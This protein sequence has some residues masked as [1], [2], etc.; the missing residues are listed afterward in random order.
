MSGMERA[1]GERKHLERWE[2]PHGTNKRAKWCGCVACSA[3][4]EGKEY[5]GPFAWPLRPLLWAMGKGSLSQLR[6][7][8][9]AEA[10]NRWQKDG[11]SDEESDEV[12]IRIARLYPGDVWRGWV[13]RGLEP[14]ASADSATVPASNVGQVHKAGRGR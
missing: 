10:V 13:D 3:A 6:K 1:K 12:A 7:V 8:C 14:L 5:D 2:V 9:G 4:K 11:L